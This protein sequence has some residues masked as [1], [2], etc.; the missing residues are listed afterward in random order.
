M[1]MIFFPFCCS[2]QIPRSLARPNGYDHRAANFGVYPYGASLQQTVYYANSTLCNDDDDD[3]KNNVPFTFVPPRDDDK[4]NKNDGHYH[5]P[6]ILMVDRGACRFITKV[7]NAQRAGAAAVL[8]ADDRCVCDH[9][10]CTHGNTHGC[11][12]S[13]PSIVDDGSG[14]DIS[15]PSFMLYKE[16]A[17]AVKQV[18][19][20]N[21][22][23]VISMGFAVPA[24]DA[25]VEYDL[26][27]LPTSDKFL[28]QQQQ[29]ADDN[30]WLSL[31]TLAV[32]MGK[33]AQFT[34]HFAII[35]GS[36][37]GC[38][39]IAPDS[40]RSRNNNNNNNPCFTMCT[41]YGR[42]CA[43]DP[44]ND[45]QVG[46]SGADIVTE[47]LRRICIWKRYG[48]DDG[49][50][51]KWWDYVHYFSTMCYKDGNLARFND[52]TCILDALRKASIEPS[53]IESCMNDSG[54]VQNDAPNVLLEESITTQRESSNV[55]LPSVWVNQVPVRGALSLKEILSAICAGF[56]EGS[57][58]DVCR[59]CVKC[60]HNVVEC[61]KTGGVCPSSNLVSDGNAGIS[62]SIFGGSLGALVI[63][64]VGIAHVHRQRERRH[65]RTH[66]RDIMVCVFR[67]LQC[68]VE[69]IKKSC[70]MN[71]ARNTCSFFGNLSPHRMILDRRSTRHY[72]IRNPPRTYRMFKAGVVTCAI[73]N[74]LR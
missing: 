72:L 32:A 2:C 9:D 25:R 54:G 20:E 51:A 57:Q 21:Q 28:Q 53:T 66:V 59:Q 22:P 13:P 71:R 16:D 34:P 7:R 17:D 38:R 68:I 6:F 11:E 60:A 52:K 50:G 14:G 44:D 58:P 23:V 4:N 74:V 42:Y 39:G 5:A 19:Q 26:W 37:Q 62:F 45:F 67:S 47:S 31:R 70:K 33:H 43:Y 27:S 24:P 35:D 56:V 61:V 55:M 63:F 48:E 1:M 8:I 10:A 15:I 18:L 64:F 12:A 40:S 49:I 73:P 29:N 65:M 30:F 3:A 36:S 69:R 41:N 46:V